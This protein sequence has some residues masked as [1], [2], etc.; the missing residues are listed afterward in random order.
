MDKKCCVNIKNTDDKCI[1]WCYLAFKHYDEVTDKNNGDSTKGYNK[2]I[3]EWNEQMSITY[4]INLDKDLP[5]LE[6]LN[7]IKINVYG[8]DSYTNR[9][10]VIYNDNTRKA[11]DEN[12]LD[13]LLIRNDTNQHFVLIKNFSRFVRAEGDKHKSYCCRNCLTY[14]T[15]DKELY[16]LHCNNCIQ[17]EAVLPTEDEKHMRFKNFNHTFQ[18]P[19]NI[20]YDFESTLEKVNE[21][22]EGGETVKYQKNIPNSYGIKL[23]C[24]YS[25]YD[26]PRVIRYSDNPDLLMRQFIEDFEVFTKYAYSLTQKHKWFNFKN[27]WSKEQQDKH[28][29][30]NFCSCEYTTEKKQVVH[31]NHMRG[32]YLDSIGNSCNLKF[33]Q[34]KFITIIAHNSKNYDSHFIV[35]YLYTYGE[36]NDSITCIPNNEEKYISFSKKIKVDEY[37]NKKNEIKNVTFEMRFIDSFGFFIY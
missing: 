31:H 14:H 23:N 1:M 25:E 30:V 24:I 3:K 20:V 13:L 22:S 21:K 7:N 34:R 4:P 36:V 9:P 16:D 8:Y 35:P 27:S 5:K 6:E 2:W 29:N 11:K 32:E 19:F 28:K 12:I 15:L 17:N 33:Q 18:H 26:K 37:K 10:F